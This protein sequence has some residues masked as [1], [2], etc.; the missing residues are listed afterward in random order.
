[1]EFGSKKT[2]IPK[3]K[4]NIFQDPILSGKEIKKEMEIESEFIQNEKIMNL[5]SQKEEEKMPIPSSNIEIDKKEEVKKELE[6]IEENDLLQ[7]HMEERQ[8]NQIADPESKLEENMELNF[9]DIPEE[10]NSIAKKMEEIYNQVKAHP[11]NNFLF[12]QIEEKKEVLLEFQEQKIEEEKKEES[13]L[14]EDL[15][16]SQLIERKE[17]EEEHEEVLKIGENLNLS[18]CDSFYCARDNE[19]DN[20]HSGNELEEE[21]HKGALFSIYS[22]G[23]IFNRLISRRRKGNFREKAIK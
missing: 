3:R 6:L 4:I 17:F 7:K 10:N 8:M 16:N 12:K 20:Y 14:K 2:Y 18:R 11:K 15:C 1:M 5:V 13:D 23:L 9:D 22:A 21:K 19:L